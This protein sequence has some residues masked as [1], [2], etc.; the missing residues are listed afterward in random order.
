MPVDG[1]C[2]GDAAVA[3]Q[4]REQRGE[5][6]PEHQRRYQSSRLA[7]V[8]LFDKFRCDEF[9]MHRFAPRDYGNDA[10]RGEQ[11][12][13]SD[14]D[15]RVNDGTRDHALGISHLAADIADVVVAQQI[16]HRD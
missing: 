11:V 13:A 16:V 3:Q 1:C 4:E 14:P 15:H 6:G 10:E 12:N 5:G 2:V 7:S 9:R 8:E